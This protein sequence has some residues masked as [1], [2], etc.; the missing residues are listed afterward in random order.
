MTSIGSLVADLDLNSAAFTAN[1]EKATRSMTASSAQMARS[2]QAVERAQANV[3]KATERLRVGIEAL[4][5]AFAVEKFREFALAAIDNADALAKTAAAVGISAKALQEYQVAAGLSGVASDDFSTALERFAKNLGDAKN[6]TGQLITI[7]GKTDKAFLDQLVSARDTGAALDLY[8]TKLADT[9][10]ATQRA[11]LASAAFGRAGVAMVNIVSEGTAGLAEMRQQAEDLGLVMSDKTL[12]A[13]E[14][15]N[16][17]ID[18]LHRAFQTSFDSGII[19]AL[20]GSLDDTLGTMKELSAIGSQLGQ[21]VGDVLLAM[22]KAAMFAADNF[23]AIEAAIAAIVAYR[24]ATIFATMA[25]AIDGLAASVATAD[26]AFAAL[27]AV[28]AANPIGLIA[29]AVSAAVA[30]LVLFSDKTVEVGGVTFQVGKTISAAWTTV[31]ESVDVVTSALAGLWAATI[32]AG[33]GDF[34][35]ARNTVIDATYDVRTAIMQINEAWD[36]ATTDFKDPAVSYGASQIRD[37]GNAAETA[38]AQLKPFVDQTQAIADAQQQLAASRISQ[39][40]LD[41]VKAQQAARDELMKWATANKIGQQAGESLADA[42]TRIEQ[43]AGVTADQLAL[44]HLA[45]GRV[46]ADLKTQ[47]DL[48]NDAAKVIEGLKTPYDVYLDQVKKDNELV[49]AGLI[50]AKQRDADLEK[51]RKQLFDTAKASTTTS[52]AMTELQRAGE[53]AAENIQD[54]FASFFQATLEG[55]VDSFSKLFQ[56]IKS[57]G[58]QTAAQLAAAFA[59]K[60]ALGGLLDSVGLTDVASTLGLGGGSAGSGLTGW[61]NSLGTSLGFSG[62]PAATAAGTSGRLAAIN[63]GGAA[64]SNLFGSAT[65]SGTL[66]AAGIGAFGGGLLAQ[67]TGGNQL[68]G[69]IGGGLGAGAGFIIGGPVGAAIGGTAGS[70][71]GSLFGP[72]KSV[73][74]NAA[75]RIVG[76]SG[77]G[78]LRLGGTGADNGGSIDGVVAVAQAAIDALN[79]LAQKLN[80]TL[81]SPQ[82]VLGSRNYIGSGAAARGYGSAEAFVTAY[83]QAGGATGANDNINK[84]LRGS[85]ASTLQDNLDLLGQIP[86]LLSPA[87]SAF[88]QSLQAVNDNFANITATAERL[89]IA[90]DKVAQAQA[91]AIEQLKLQATAPYT[92]TAG[93]IVD[94]INAQRLSQTSTLSPTDR[95]AEAQRQFGDIVARV[96][97]GQTGLDQAL[98]SAA[99]NVLDIGRQLYASS[100]PFASLERNIDQTLL[101][102]AGTLTNTDWQEQQLEATKQQTDVLSGDLGEVR[103]AVASLQREIVLL[104][105][106][107]LAA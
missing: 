7:L 22:G 50:S 95:L 88:E 75:A 21:V 74:E 37:V 31:A 93:S 79:G 82:S 23:R 70:L 86:G 34:N 57:I 1:L 3:E 76:N 2:M 69:S 48:R 56:A 36:T 92:Q 84:L 46:N 45:L 25:V 39:E 87:T 61:L 68:G 14:D 98:T 4:A 51:L 19:D 105:Q 103:D 72:G 15:L 81:A 20:A 83:L 6:G 38:T 16:D 53:H 5:G 94:F 10:D 44:E 66:G 63:S 29:V 102:L 101:D 27:G 99:G 58:I 100:G 89:G 42:M 17:Q 47:T 43:A 52:A 12:K 77:V 28:I 67:F 59:I 55:G 18:L 11:S 90:T 35:A 65:L 60:P 78:G 24:A 13:A 80:L 41:Y 96:Q 54:A 85:T 40:T 8:F 106:S 64:A 30:A 33:T 49:K 71:L 26:G 97:A 104:R 91:D 107:L 73:G 62:G 32:Q 9:A